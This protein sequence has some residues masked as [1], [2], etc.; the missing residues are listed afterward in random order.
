M[1]HLTAHLSHALM[2]GAP[3]AVFVLLL[4]LEWR[5]TAEGTVPAPLRLMAVTGAAAGVLH[6]AVVGHHSAQAAVLGWFFATACAV[7]VAQALALVFAPV[8]RVVVPGVLVNL[9]LVALWAWTRLVGVPLGVDGGQ[10]QLVRP[11]DVTCTLLEVVAVLA[12]LAWVYSATG[13]SVRSALSLKWEKST[14]RNSPPPLKTTVPS[15]RVPSH[16]T[17]SL[18]PSRE[19]IRAASS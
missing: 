11:L 16:D 2:L 17:N 7:Q 10:R 5:R 19:S 12:G 18:R 3:A 14:V 15:A 1:T 8:R 13:G 4:A 6:G 9:G